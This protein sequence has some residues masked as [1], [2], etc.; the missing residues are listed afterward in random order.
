[1]NKKYYIVVT[2]FFPTA[3][4]FRG[5]FIYEQV[6]ALKRNSDYEIVVFRPIQQIKEPYYDY[7]GVR[8][9]YFHHWQMPSMILNGLTDGLGQ[10]SLLNKLRELGILL[11]NVAVVHTHTV[12]M[13]AMALAVKK[14]NPAVKTIVQHH[15]PDPYGIRNGRLS[16]KW[17]NVQYRARHAKWLFEQV[18]LHVSVSQYV[19]QN[20]LLFPSCSAHDIDE[21]YLHVLSKVKNM[22]RTKIKKSVV[23]YNGVDVKQFYQN[24]V[25]HEG[26]VIGCVANMGD[27]KD[28]L[29]L[30]KAIEILHQKGV[31]NLTLNFIGSG[32]ERENYECYVREH[33]LDGC[34]HFLK[35]VQHDQLPVF[36]NTLDL[37]VLPS[38]FEGFGCVF[39][40]AASCGVPFMICEGQGA[41]EYLAENEKNQWTFKPK[42]YQTLAKLIEMQMENQCVQQ[43]VEPLNID[44]LIIRFLKNI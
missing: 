11:E 13:A 32:E 39:T 5:P 30:I 36:F 34:I 23:L 42:D 14:Y 35:E 29:T 44:E 22:S 19:E 4:S 3:E 28:Q 27:W 38:Y 18:D 43:L 15:D 33:G 20:L 24:P 31:Q 10:R 37:F 17:W 2:P 7:R 21:K 9:H 8:V 16:E 6:Q 25:P 12:S 1:M 26:F 40:E 41:S